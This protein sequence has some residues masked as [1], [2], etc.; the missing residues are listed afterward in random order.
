MKTGITISLLVALAVFCMPLF[1][2]GTKEA[3][4]VTSTTEG[5]PEYGG[6]LT[7]WM[8]S[9]AQT[10]EPPSPDTE[11]GYYASLAYLN[12]M[13]ETVMCGDIEK[14]GPRG[15]N[16]F[17]FQ[18]LQYQPVK[19]LRGNVVDSWQLQP[20]SFVFHVRPGVYWA[21]TEH[22]LAWMEAREI[23]AEDLADDLRRVVRSPWGSKYKGYITDIDADIYAEND[24]VV[25]ELENYARTILYW[26]CW[27]DRAVTSPP[28]LHAV[29]GRAKTWQN[30]VGTGPF[31]FEEYITGSHMKF[32]RNP[33]Y[34]GKTTINGKEYQLPFVDYMVLPIMPDSSTQMAALQTGVVEVYREVPMDFWETLDRI[35]PE[36]V[37]WEGSFGKGIAPY[38]R[39]DEPPFDDPKVRQAV[40]FG[41]DVAE[42]QA[43]VGAKGLQKDFSPLFT[44]HAAYTPPE[45][46]PAEI[47]KLRKYDYDPELAR[48][49]LADAGYPEGFATTVLVRAA[50][51]EML[52]AAALLKDQW[53]KIGVELTL[54]PRDATSF[55][56]M[57]FCYPP[58][59]LP[60]YH[61][62]C[63]DW[64]LAAPD[65]LQKWPTL[66]SFSDKNT[67]VLRDPEFDELIFQA[68]AEMDVDE[69][70][71]ILK[72]CG[73]FLAVKNCCIPLTLMPARTSWWP[74]VKN[75]YGE[76]TA[77]DDLQFCPVAQY[78]WIDQ[79]LKEEM[80]FK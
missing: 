49:M 5:E 23:T 41:T 43:L 14:Y 52:D 38:M 46:M 61:G 36:L 11:D 15:T 80:G 55:T 44:S 74:W 22:Q 58:E 62:I 75:Y 10:V 12:F 9:R 19:Y 16:D 28:E 79:A 72:E 3:A 78:I 1:A 71:K 67:P 69:Q 47:R 29:S 2:A 39:L 53:S 4:E 42:F 40:V 56:R 66:Q 73:V 76:T 35:A 17:S 50:S 54:D 21:P 68:Q 34:W 59:N 25:V 18:Y 51:P 6:T 24:T 33:E 31:M 63:M 60:M 7:L 27:E 77:T 26:L 32:K 48:K 37:K 13:Q 30:Q 57:Y 64:G 70:N 65:P 20:D 8:D 45:E